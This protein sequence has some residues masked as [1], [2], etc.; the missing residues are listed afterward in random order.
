[1]PNG[2]LEKFVYEGSSLTDCQL[3]WEKLS[4]IAIGIARGLEYLHRGC[5]TRILHLDIKPHNI[6]LDEDFSPK[7]SDFGLAK[8][9]P[10]KESVVSMLNARG[11][12]G[13]IAPEE[14]FGGFSHKSDVYSYGM[15]VLEM[16]GGTNKIKPEVDHSS[17]M[18][19][20]DWIYNHLESGGRIL[21]TGNDEE[22]KYNV[23]NNA[24]RVLQVKS[25]HVFSQVG[26]LKMA[27]TT[28]LAV[29]LL[30]RL[31]L[32][33]SAEDGKPSCSVLLLPKAWPRSLPILYIVVLLLI[34]DA[35][36]AS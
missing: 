35:D 4:Q 15:M 28:F 1:M 25:N 31:A 13:Y 20:P 24:I 5:N 2:S 33:H 16:V 3:G 32:L 8:L 21:G 10:R 19:F 36:C 14:L 34:Y 11:T 18:Y 27:L 9:C 22:F 6:L 17:E 29:F 7:I 30:S 23:G 26:S 12:V